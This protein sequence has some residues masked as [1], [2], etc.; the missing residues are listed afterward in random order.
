MAQ[1]AATIASVLKDAWTSDRIVKQFESNNTVLKKVEK[2]K[3]T[4]IGAQAQVPIHAGRSFAFTSTGAAGGSLNAAQYQPTAQATFSLVYNWFQIAIQ[5]SALVQAASNAQSVIAAKDLELQGAIENTAHQINRAV[6]TNGDGIV[7]ACAT[8]GASTTVSLLPAASE[9]TAYGYA[10]LERGWLA[11]GAKVDIGTTADTDS[12]VTGATISAV[13]LSATSPTITID[14]SVSTTAGT[15]FVYIPNPNS[16][17]AANPELNGLRQIVNTTGAIGG[18]NPATA[19]QEYWQA[20]ARDTTTSVLSLDLILGLQRAVLQNTNTPGQAIITGYKQQ[21]QFYSLLQN[22]VRFSGDGDLSAGAVSKASWNGMSIDAS[23]DVLNTDLFIITPGDLCKVVGDI[24][25]PTWVS[26]I[27]GANNG[28]L[29]QS[30]TTKFADA[31]VYP[32]QL[33]VQRRNSHA[34]ATAL[35]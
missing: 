5:A 23:A 2:F 16:A 6:L 14:S 17:S 25:K 27:Q 7:A 12:V 1:S 8:G 29:W 26:D 31:C 34:A 30:D 33:G 21:A 32:I 19:G 3:G 18:L 10:A 13:S 11:P 35:T 22:Q 28:V 4:M 24:D 15:H 20:A 9:G